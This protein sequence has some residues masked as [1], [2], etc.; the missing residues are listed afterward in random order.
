MSNKERLSLETIGRVEKWPI[1]RSN[2]NQYKGWWGIQLVTAGVATIIIVG[3]LQIQDPTTKENNK[4]Q[5]NP[6]PAWLV[7][8]VPVWESPELP[9]VIKRAE[10]PTEK[11]SVQVKE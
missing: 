4:D 11:H 3:I 10:L 2:K 6:D 7:A 9:E 8:E 1:S 5:P